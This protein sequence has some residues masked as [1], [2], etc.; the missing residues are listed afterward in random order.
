MTSELTPTSDVLTEP[1]YLLGITWGP[2]TSG[3]FNDPDNYWVVNFANLGNLVFPGGRDEAILQIDNYQ[4]DRIVSAMVT[5]TLRRRNVECQ[6]WSAGFNNLLM[7][8][9]PELCWKST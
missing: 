5:V 6:I 8:G 7:P 4:P 1:A 2:L 9:K 3:L